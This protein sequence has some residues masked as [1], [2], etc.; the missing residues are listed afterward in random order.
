MQQC[1][2]SSLDSSLHNTPHT[3]NGSQKEV[4]NKTLSISFNFLT[5]ESMYISYIA[6]DSSTLLCFSTML[7]VR[8]KEDNLIGRRQQDSSKLPVLLHFSRPTSTSHSCFCLR[9][10]CI[11]RFSYFVFL[12]VC[13]NIAILQAT[14]NYHS[15]PCPCLYL[16]ISVPLDYGHP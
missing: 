3:L 13:L 16:Y 9:V 15:C 2:M 11:L 4:K 12:L 7:C 5:C 6:F 10:F 14:T 8:Q 1:T